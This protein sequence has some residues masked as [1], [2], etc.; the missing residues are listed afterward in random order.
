MR[1]IN[2]WTRNKRKWCNGNKS[3]RSWIG[4]KQNREEE[5]SLTTYGNIDMK[6]HISRYYDFAF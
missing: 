4:K 1:I 3:N 2:Y 6:D 5:L